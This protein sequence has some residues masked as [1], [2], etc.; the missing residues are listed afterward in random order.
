MS[1]ATQLGISEREYEEAL[2]VEKLFFL[3]S[4]E[5]CNYCNS[6]KP[7]F[8]D[9]YNYE[10][11]C[12]KCSYKSKHKKK[13]G[14]DSIS[15]YD[16]QKLERKFGSSGN[17]RHN[18]HH[19][20][21]SYNY[22]K[23]SKSKSRR[24]SKKYADVTS[25]SSDSEYEKMKKEKKKKKEK[26][27]EKHKEKHK[28]KYKK[29]KKNEE[30]DDFDD[31]SLNDYDNST[32]GMIGIMNSNKINSSDYK[33][34][35]DTF[36]DFDTNHLSYNQMN[37]KSFNDFNKGNKM[38]HIQF[39]HFQKN[40]FNTKFIRTPNNQQINSHPLCVDDFN[41][42]YINN[43]HF[44]N[45]FNI[46]LNE[47]NKLNKMKYNKIS[48]HPY[49]PFDNNNNNNNNNN[50]SNNNNRYNTLDNLNYFNNSNFP[51]NQ[52]A[53]NNFYLLNKRNLLNNQYSANNS[54]SVYN[55]HLLKNPYVFNNHN[56]SN[57]RIHFDNDASN[58]GLIFPNSKNCPFILNSNLNKANNSTLASN[59]MNF[60]SH[61]NQSNVNELKK[62]HDIYN[63]DFSPIIVSDKNPFS[64]QNLISNGNI[65]KPYN[66]FN[67]LPNSFNNNI[68][69]NRNLYKPMSYP[70]FESDRRF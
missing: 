44:P 16:V 38:N 27:K 17:K 42:M 21:S 51:N 22:E 70:V 24:S 28:E 12:D 48:M 29:K 41:A 56:K 14:E 18:K 30:T 67:S 1:S 65:K 32:P 63:S 11:L 50:S 23:K 9:T 62:F 33:K 3:S 26:E 10:F 66:V 52:N 35:V 15:Y 5:R 6:G 37:Q 40:N 31:F 49:D 55:H 39:D 43:T 45:N 57:T 60:L 61:C 4:K 36:N 64:L 69:M 46:K 47:E 13:I 8:V 19:R 58:K 25:D 2:A 68:N 59:N 53:M 7:T 54:N 20:K 34:D